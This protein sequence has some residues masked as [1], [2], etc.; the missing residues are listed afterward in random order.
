MDPINAMCPEPPNLRVMLCCLLLVSVQTAT[1][2]ESLTGRPVR[3][4]SGNA[5]V[6][7]DSNGIAH[8]V[9]LSGIDTQPPNQ[10][11]GATARRHLQTL[12]MGRSVTLIYPGRGRTEE[13]HGQLRH[14]G[15]DINIRLLSA[16]LARF[17]PSGLSRTDAER[18]AAAERRARMK[19]LGIWGTTGRER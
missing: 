16:G 3:I 4:I 13:I 11:W 12:V 5:L 18:Y 15:A 8:R 14:G 7:V 6:L 17:D 1:A 2:I 9:K 19:R 10:P